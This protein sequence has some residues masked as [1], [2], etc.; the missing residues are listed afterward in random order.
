MLD[1][2]NRF[3]LVFQS[4]DYCSIIP[5]WVPPVELSWIDH[6]WGCISEIKRSEVIKSLSLKHYASVHN[7]WLNEYYQYQL[8]TV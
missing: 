7:L 1:Y 4:L 6:I 3:W 5:L 8:Y 2:F